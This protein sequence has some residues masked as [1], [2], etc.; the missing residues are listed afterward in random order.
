VK[1]IEKPTEFPLDAKIGQV[2]GATIQ[3]IQICLQTH[4]ILHE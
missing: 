1:R 4:H 3:L 2:V